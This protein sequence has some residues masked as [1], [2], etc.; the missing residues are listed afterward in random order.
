[1]AA[2]ADVGRQLLCRWLGAPANA[3]LEVQHTAGPLRGTACQLAVCAA[4]VKAGERSHV[5][6]AFVITSANSSSGAGSRSKG[7][8]TVA[9]LRSPVL[10]WGC[11]AGQGDRWQPPPA[12][13]S[14]WPDVS[15]D[16]RAWS[17][18]GCRGL[19][20]TQPA[21]RAHRR[22]HRACMHH[23]MHAHPHAC[24]HSQR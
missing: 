20:L 16:A 17:R 19:Q 6:L 18:Q 15:H 22:M 4:T 24:M 23:R 2:A 9:E 1:M 11:V 5:L 12:G 13:W 21:A 10:H 3:P 7:G 8:A 14:T